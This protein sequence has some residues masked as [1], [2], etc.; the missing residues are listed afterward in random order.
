MSVVAVHMR[1]D[2]RGRIGR[3]DVDSVP[4]CRAATAARMAPTPFLA[5]E[6]PTKKLL[7]CRIGTN[8]SE[9]LTVS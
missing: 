2:K 3:E 4:L 5:E 9:A 1:E 8:I 6:R 7:A